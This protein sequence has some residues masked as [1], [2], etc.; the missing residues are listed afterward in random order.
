MV[1]RI[2]RLAVLSSFLV[3][4]GL[5]TSVLQAVAWARMAVQFAR[6]DTVSVSLEKTFDGR[7]S[8]PIC[9]SLRKAGDQSSLAAAPTRSRLAFVSPSSAPRASRLAIA[10]DG[11]HRASTA[12]ARSLRPDSPPPKIALA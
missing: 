2:A 5:H 6:Q 3:S 10:W 1:N 11:S 12:L 9:V 8:C 7:H 4:M